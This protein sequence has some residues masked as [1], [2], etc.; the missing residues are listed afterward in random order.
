[1]IKNDYISLD[2]AA[3]QL[4]VTTNSLVVA[5]TEGK[6][7]LFALVDA[8]GVPEEDELFSS[9]NLYFPFAHIHHPIQLLREGKAKI[10]RLTVP[11][12]GDAGLYENWKHLLDEGTRALFEEK[13]FT[14]R[15]WRTRDLNNETIQVTLEQV[16]I[17]SAD[18]L[19]F[20]NN[21]GDESVTKQTENKNDGKNERWNESALKELV[22][23]K[24]THTVAQT[25]EQF[26]IS[27]G[28][29]YELVRKYKERHS[30]PT[31]NNPFG[32]Q[33]K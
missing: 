11:V 22:E 21:Q 9:E 19:R 15:Q 13:G 26:Q 5:S 24:N 7:N 3:R 28:R 14:P 4:G 6:I 31:A 30:K 33:I 2:D 16:Y 29:V 27:E 17:R 8:Y 10:T 20:T 18:L 1:M 32:I 25:A 23:F 12:E